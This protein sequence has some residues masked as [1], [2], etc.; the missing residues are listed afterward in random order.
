ML[1]TNLWVFM[2]NIENA[3]VYL[4]DINT[5][6]SKEETLSY[7]PNN[8]LYI[9]LPINASQKTNQK[10]KYRYEKPIYVFQIILITIDYQVSYTLST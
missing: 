1:Q 7:V 2:M 5:K 6:S 8:N 9:I 4:Q 3:K 10:T